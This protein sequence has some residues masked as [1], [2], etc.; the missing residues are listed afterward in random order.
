LTVLADTF[1]QPGWPVSE[2]VKAFVT[3]REGGVSSSPYDSLNLGTHVGDLP[4]AVL[5][6]RQ[7]LKSALE[8][9]S[10]PLWLEQVHGIEVIDGYCAPACKADASYT[11]KPGVVCTVMTADCLPVF[12]ADKK[13]NEVAV[14]HAGWK[15][16][17]QG[18]IEA[19]VK[20]FSASPDN[21]C[22]WLGPA[23]GPDNFEVGRDVL[24]AFMDEAADNVMERE[25]VQ[26]A[27]RRRENRPE[28]YLADIYQLARIRLH[29]VGVKNISGGEFCTVENREMFYSYRRDG[30]TGRMASLIWIDED[31]K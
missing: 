29:R 30:V 13:G 6:N 5:Q 18:I 22:V 19:S 23:I 1:I 21:V 2:R 9:P 17:L 28:K 31:K 15:G 11:S 26:R 14:V 25:A 20:K 8:L 4:E 24:Q 16:L 10:E 12:V 27:F 7:I 3:T